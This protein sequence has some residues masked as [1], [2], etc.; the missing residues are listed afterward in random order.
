MPLP[1]PLIRP[2]R[3]EDSEEV[4]RILKANGQYRFPL[5]DGPQALQRVHRLS[6]FL[7]LVA[8]IDGRVVGMIRGVWD[9]SRALI[10]QLSVHPDHQR[11]G[12]GTTL[13]RAIARRFR[14]KGAPTIAVT[15]TQETRAFYERLG[16]K[17]VDV[18]FMLA[19]DIR[20]VTGEVS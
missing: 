3:P 18:I 14:Q 1:S 8:E 15:A 2:F 9:G 16:F 13:V 4:I 12:I 19:K 7:F 10:H 5:V 20:T 6:G 11:Q 17:S